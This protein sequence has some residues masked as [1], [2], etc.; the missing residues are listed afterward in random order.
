MEQSA[1]RSCTIPSCIFLSTHDNGD[2][3]HLDNVG[4]IASRI[5]EPD[6]LV[7]PKRFRDGSD[8]AREPLPNT[9]RSNGANACDRTV[10]HATVLNAWL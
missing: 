3:A 10:S 4:R 1:P 9:V 5:L 7:A 8:C 6:T 2:V